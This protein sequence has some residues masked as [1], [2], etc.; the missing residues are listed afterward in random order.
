M[1]LNLSDEDL[2]FQ[3]RATDWL[4][5]NIPTEKRPSAGAGMR[6]YDLAWISKQSKGGWGGIS[7]PAEY[8]GCGVS[9][10]QQ[11]LWYEA[12]AKASAPPIGVG[13]VG[14]NFGG[15][16]L[17]TCGTKAQC[18]EH[19][20]RILDGDVVWCQGFSEPN[21]GSDL[22]GLETQ[23]IVHDDYIEVT[24]QKIWTS[25]ADLAD[26]QLLLIR[27][28]KSSA[29]HSGLTMVICDMK[30]EGVDVRPIQLIS[31]ESHFSEVFYDSVK[32]PKSNVIGEVGQGWRVA[33]ATLGFERGAAFI[34]DQISLAGKVEEL[35]ELAKRTNWPTSNKLAIDDDE[36]ARGLAV[37]R[38][39]VSGLRAMTYGDIA[40]RGVGDPPG[41]EGSMNKLCY[42][43]LSQK[44]NRLAFRILGSDALAFKYGD[45]GWTRDYF[46]SYAS[47]VG[48]GTSEIQKEIIAQRVLELPRGRKG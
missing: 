48:G 42:S 31:G 46:Y 5:A 28:D 15:P 20:P 33:M 3:Q 23:G 36:I 39:E 25:Y 14:L 4:L 45:V 26:Y 18:D 16:T 34:A 11:L 1:R 30:S 38:A 41:P 40:Q 22:G 43:D 35:I 7:W 44:L 10:M 2:E 27:T 17:I 32:I 47:S 9:P 19:L 29:K 13:M 37:L 8:G 24:G 12:S 21:A 6:E